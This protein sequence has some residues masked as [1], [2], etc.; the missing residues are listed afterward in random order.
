MVLGINFSNLDQLPLVPA[1]IRRQHSVDEASDQRFTACARLLQSV[2]RANR[3]LAVGQHKPAKGKGRKLGSRLTAAAAETGVTF[4]TPE[5]A[6]IVWTQCAYREPGALIDEE[7]LWGNLLSSQALTFNLFALAS[8]QLRLADKIFSALAPQII[9]TVHRARFEHSPGRGDPVYLGD[10]TA[11]DVIVEG[12]AP[13]GSDAILVIEVKY[14]EQSGQAYRAATDL[15]RQRANEAGFYV[16][17]EDEMFRNP[18]TSQLV[19][20]H[21]LAERIRVNAKE[22][23]TVGFM[24]IAPKDNVFAQSSCRAYRRLLSDAEAI[25]VP[26]IERTLEECIEVIGMAGAGDL[27]ARLHERYVDFT[28]VR[29]LIEGWQPPAP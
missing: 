11:F 6:K 22:P 1:L 24:I 21:L 25:A 10:H 20:E 5:I 15:I 9:H 18:F 7:R 4:L 26:F 29:L 12:L 16:E 28:P 27:E 14:S 19:A 17:V 8:L 13:D 23:T 2:W 3:N